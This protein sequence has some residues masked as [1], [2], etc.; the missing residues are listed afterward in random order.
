LYFYNVIE[1][2][3][4]EKF[5]TDLDAALLENDHNCRKIVSIMGGDGSLATTIK[6]LRTSKLVDTGLT[7]GKIVFCMLP[8]GTGNDGPQVFGWGASPVGELWLADLDSLMRDMILSSTESLSLWNCDVEG[9]VLSA[10]GETLSS[11]I[12]M[13]YY[14]NLGIDAEV[15]IEVERN[16][17]RRRCCN[18]FLYLYFALRS[19]FQT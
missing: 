4:R 3:E 12:L 10:S 11:K 5:L 1:K 13:C 6:F 17:T 15:G 19:L 18:Y 7:K 14:F 8:F 2:V 16:R 9:K